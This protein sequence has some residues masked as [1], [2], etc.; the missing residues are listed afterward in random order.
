MQRRASSGLTVGIIEPVGGHSGMDYY[1]FGLC[2]GLASQGVNVELYTCDETRQESGQGYTTH[3][4]YQR[5]FGQD[6]AWKRGFRYLVGSI[7]SLFHAKY[8]GARISHFHFFHVG[9]LE[10]FNIILARLLGMRVVITA[11]DVESFVANLENP[12]FLQISY[13]LAQLIIAHNLTS[14]QDL[15]ERLMVPRSK[16]WVIPHGNYLQI[17]NSPPDRVEARKELTIPLDAKVLLFFGQIK[18]IKG[19]DLLIQALPLVLKSFPESILLIAGKVWKDDLSRYEVLIQELG[20]QEHCVLDIRYIPDEE[21]PLFYGSA[22]LVIFPYRRIY[23]SGAL[24]MAMSFGKPVLASDLQGM[25]EII[26]DGQT[27]FLFPDGQIDY[28]AEKIVSILSNPEKA[29]E[30]GLAGLRI[31]ERD[32]DWSRIG[33]LTK[34]CYQSIIPAASD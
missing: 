14:S 19:V 11:H 16:I 15:A 7:R 13:R 12:R 3:R 8:V 29:N 30:V 23:Q 28:L 32:F 25:K 18:Q 27:G 9:I 2:Q 10:F 33:E 4:F 26:Q 5:I 1:D 17:F 20:L 22:D 31:M 24:L 6:I 21:V 34:A